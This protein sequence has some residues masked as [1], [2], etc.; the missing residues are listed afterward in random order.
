MDDVRWG[1]IGAGAVTEVK[2]GPAFG[3]IENSALVAVMRRDGDKARDYARRHGIPRWTADANELIGDP[4]VNAVYVA[5]PPDS[6]AEYAIRAMRAGKPVYVEK[7][8]ALTY[9][10]CQEMLAVSRETGQPL[11][12][13][14]Y[15]RRLPNFLKVKE[16][17]DQGAIG[18]VLLVTVQLVWPARPADLDAANP[19]WRVLPQVGGDGYFYDVG[20]HQLDLLDFFFGPIARAG[21]QAANRSGVYPASDVVTASFAFQSGLP[22]SGAWCFTA[23]AEHRLDRMEIL[24]RRGK[25][26]FPSIDHGVVRL[27]TAGAVEEFNLPWPEHVQQPLIR[28]VVAALLGRGDCPSTGASAARTNRWLEAISGR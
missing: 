5:T 19:S 24:G 3:K 11:F 10:E 22:G 4:A 23:P 21:G 17:L 18:D 25:L 1:M 13:A 28:T 8:M 14:Y 20:S 27:E 2:S 9:A 15:R 16:L 26:T 12:V 6:H 7:P